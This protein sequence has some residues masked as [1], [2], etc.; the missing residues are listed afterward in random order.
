MQ[1]YCRGARARL[2]RRGLRRPAVW[3]E[4]S[5]LTFYSVRA[6]A[7]FAR[8]RLTEAWRIRPD[9]T[10]GFES[11]LIAVNPGKSNLFKVNQSLIHSV[12]TVPIANRF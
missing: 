6:V 8:T 1:H 4:R 7:A 10:L 12:A 11:N 2:L 3:A 5:S 9:R